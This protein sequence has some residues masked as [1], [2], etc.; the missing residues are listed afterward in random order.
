[1][2]IEITEVPLSQVPCPKHLEKFVVDQINNKSLHE[3][4][5]EFLSNFEP[6]SLLVLDIG[7]NIG[8]SLVSIGLSA[9][10]CDVIGFE[11]NTSLKPIQNIARSFY[12]RCV[13]Y[14]FGLAD[15]NGNR[16]LYIPVVD[17]RHI[18]GESSMYLE[19]FDDGVVSSRLKS[20]SSDGSFK[21]D[22]CT[23]MF[24]RLD[25]VPEII[26]FCVQA[27]TIVAKI[28]VEGAEVAV[29]QGMDSFLRKFKPILL[30]E[31]GER[32]DISDF[33]GLYGYKRYLRTDSNQLRLAG[34]EMALNSFFAL[35]R[36]LS[37]LIAA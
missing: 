6:D 2:G 20:Y 30:I 18:S 10:G 24:R 37:H 32:P 19:H 5:F 14:P 34:D 23:M 36:E 15:F 8:N 29:L 3:P 16:N 12:S 26:P 7:A 22:S 11:P 17:G 4:D 28:D 9:P 35:P 31:N 13:I 21:L 33:L 27:Q 25:D 1:V